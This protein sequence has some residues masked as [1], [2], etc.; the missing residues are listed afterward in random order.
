MQKLTIGRSRRQKAVRDVLPV[1]AAV[2]E[3]DRAGTHLE[4]SGDRRL[5]FVIPESPHNHHNVSLGQLTHRVGLP[6]SHGHRPVASPVQHILGVGAPLEVLKPIIGPNAVEMG[7]LLAGW[8]RPG[9]RRQNQGVDTAPMA[10]AVLAEVDDVVSSTVRHEAEQPPRPLHSAP[11]ATY[12]P[13]NATDSPQGA[14][15]V[16]SNETGH[17]C[18]L[19]DM[20]C[21]RLFIAMWHTTS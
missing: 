9:A 1:L 15:L 16:E 7:A 5:G 19:F 3:T 21:L 4:V 17:S 10:G 12:L 6:F 8:S 11:P 13:V 20:L 2:Y 14:G 18:P